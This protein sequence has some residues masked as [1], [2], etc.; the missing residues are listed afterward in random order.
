MYYT[1]QL[2]EAEDF[3]ARVEEDCRQAAFARRGAV[4][5]AAPVAESALGAAQSEEYRPQV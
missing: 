5:S 1:A 4:P 2:M 3:C